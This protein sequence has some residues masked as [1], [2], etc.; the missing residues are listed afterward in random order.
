MR[1]EEHPTAWRLFIKNFSFLKPSTTHV[2]SFLDEVSIDQ[3]QLSEFI[4]PKNQAI[5]LNG[6]RVLAPE[7]LRNDWILG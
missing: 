7:W 5:V 3:L 1:Y 6:E 4:P 2:L